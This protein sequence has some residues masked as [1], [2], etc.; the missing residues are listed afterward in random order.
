M[1]R[2]PHGICGEGQE[3]P[4]VPWWPFLEGSLY[5][6]VQKRLLFRDFIISQ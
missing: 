2:V 6:A 4:V 3:S 5:N 1:L